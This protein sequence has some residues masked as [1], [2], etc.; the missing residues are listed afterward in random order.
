MDLTLLAILGLVALFALIFLVNVDIGIAMG[1][2]GFA[3]IWISRG[4]I[5]A[6]TCIATIPYRFAMDYTF[7]VLPLFMLIGY[8]AGATRLSTDAF[9]AANKWFGHMR[10]GLAM[11][12][13]VACTIF[14]AISGCSITTAI[15]VATVSLPEMRR[16][17]YDD[18]LSLGC[19][20]AGGNLGFV[21]PPSIGFIIYAMLTEMSIGD[22]FLA[23]ILPGLLQAFL[24]MLTVYIYVRIQPSAAPTTT[25]ASW[26]E[27]FISLKSVGP[28]LLII[29]MVLGGIYGGLFTPTEAA[30]AGV[31]CI[32]ILG[33]AMGRLRWVGFVDSLKETA[34][35]AGTIFILMIGGIIFN[36][37]MVTAEVPQKLATFIMDLQ[38]PP[39]AVLVVVLIAYIVLGFIMNIMAV[40]VFAVPLLHPL[41]VTL[42]FDPIWLAVLTMTTVTMGHISPPVGIVVFALSAVVGV[43]VVKI[44]RG[45]LPFLAASLLCLIILMYFPEISLFLVHLMKVPG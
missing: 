13:V 4:L 40:V 2:I 23:G 39:F 7:S 15:T 43:P 19:I 18:Q 38:I 20:A 41:L 10:G 8:L 17:K 27:R 24:F 26:V 14:A 37:F 6:Y 3:G 29:I 30:A 31:F 25:K 9:T 28:S 44:F 21:I 16:F 35:L 34:K 36:T 5:P 1:I 33:L 45:A 11:G 22:L 32:A 42:G 12:T